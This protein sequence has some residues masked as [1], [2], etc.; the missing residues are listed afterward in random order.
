MK[1][2]IFFYV[3]ILS[4]C[5]LACACAALAFMNGSLKKQL[6]QTTFLLGKVES[7]AKQLQQDKDQA[8]KDNEKL[9][10][11]AMSYIALNNELRKDKELL[12]ARVNDSLQ[13]IDVQK[14]E[15]VKVQHEI[16]LLRKTSTAKSNAERALL[17]EKEKML[18]GI[19]KLEDSI[20]RER[21]I[22]HYNLAVAY[23]KAMFIPKA[24]V[25]YEKSLAY[26]PNNA[27][28]HFNLGLLYKG[29]ANDAQK[30]LE[31]FRRYLELKPDAED[32]VDVQE[33]ID[34]LIRHNDRQLSV[35]QADETSEKS[36]Y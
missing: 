29:Q 36:R 6:D 12:Q 13:S 4:V 2:D 19:R 8:R 23:A 7:S 31:H 24:V 28:A 16:D 26:D 17:K 10:A 15:L 35:L 9:Q 25:E 3:K 33:S 14:K 11:D 27:E 30:A 34:T 5:L 1:K 18:A 21:G 22:Y 32:A 20:N